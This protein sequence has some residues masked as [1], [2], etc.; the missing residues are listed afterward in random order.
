MRRIARE[1]LE[2][3]LVSVRWSPPLAPAQVAADFEESARACGVA[4]AAPFRWRIKIF[5]PLRLL[6]RLRP[7]LACRA[8]EAGLKP[9]TE[10][11]FDV[12]GHRF[13]L[14]VGSRSVRLGKGKLG[15]SHLAMSVPDLLKMALG[16]A[17]GESLCEAGEIR[18]STQ[19]ACRCAGALF[20]SVRWWL[21]SWD[22]MPSREL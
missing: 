12:D 2:H 11:G 15:R 4:V 21:S 13:Q 16:A 10:L 18:A 17:S 19:L 5:H 20:P 1:A 9:G 7:T 3:D 8:R 14:A 22:E 6:D